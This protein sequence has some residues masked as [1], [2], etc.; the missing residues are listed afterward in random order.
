MKPNPC[1]VKVNFFLTLLVLSVFIIHQN[2]LFVSAS[3]NNEAL[4]V[5]TQ[6]EKSIDEVMIKLDALDKK[7][8]ELME[9]SQDTIDYYRDL[10]NEYYDK[11]LRLTHKH[12][13]YSSRLTSNED[14]FI[15]NNIFKSN[16]QEAPI[17]LDLRENSAITAYEINEF[18]LKGTELYGLGEAFVKAELEHDVNAMFLLSLA[19]HESAWGKSKIAREKNN[20]FGFGAYDD[21]PYQSAIHFSSKSEGIDRV[22]KHLSESYLKEDG[23]NFSGGYTL[24][25]VNKKY[26]SDTDWSRKIADTMEKINKKIMEKQ[27]T[28]Y[29]EDFYIIGEDDNGEPQYSV[30]F[31]ATIE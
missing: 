18:I 12:I 13:T 14:T 27:D 1:R 5:G 17:H 15:K 20:L 21:S 25:H 22:A 6:K 10:Y 28:N 3:E 7:V 29:H 26:A 16:K 23:S 2:Y 11:D 30:L 8:S 9:I 19:I 4:Y 24:V 31:D